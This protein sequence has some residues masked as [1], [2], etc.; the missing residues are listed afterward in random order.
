VQRLVMTCSL[1]TGEWNLAESVHFRVSFVNFR[2]S[3][4]AVSGIW[5]TKFEI[6][7]GTGPIDC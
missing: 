2:E 6:N 1:L 4:M 5:K 7:A 3:G